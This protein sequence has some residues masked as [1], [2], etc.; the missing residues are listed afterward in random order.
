[1][2]PTGQAQPL[3]IPR[4]TFC[5]KTDEGSVTMLCSCLVGAVIHVVLDLDETVL[6]PLLKQP[7]ERVCEA[8]TVKLRVEAPKSSRQLCAPKAVSQ[9]RPYCRL[10]A[11]AEPLTDSV[12]CH[13]PVQ[14]FTPVQ[15]PERLGGA[16]AF[17][18][19][20]PVVLHIVSAG[21]G[22]YVK[23]VRGAA[24]DSSHAKMIRRQRL[25]V[26]S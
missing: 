14:I 24:H 15:I 2:H 23:A 16:M 18:A 22:P 7:D 19:N 13:R 26:G 11:L 17:I 6:A 21:N 10:A 25:T 9:P 4:V 1:M 5:M 3:I 8:E 20:L 12:T